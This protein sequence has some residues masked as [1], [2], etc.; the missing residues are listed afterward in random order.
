MRRA[1][2]NMLSGADDIEVQR[3]AQGGAIAL[4]RIR[5]CHPDVVVLDVEMPGM[6]GLE[7]LTEI[8]KLYPK[9]PVIMFSSLTG[10][11]TSTTVEALALGAS[12]YLS[13]PSSLSTGSVATD[14]QVELLRKIRAL[15][16]SCSAS[17]SPRLRPTPPG[18]TSRTVSQGPIKIVLIACSTGGPNALTSVIPNLPADL[19]V[20]V[21][22]VQ[23]M[24]PI[25]TGLLADRLNKGSKLTV[26]EASAGDRPTPNGCWLA[27][28]DY[29]MVLERNQTGVSLNLNQEPA[30]NSCRPAA[31]ALF[32]SAVRAYG[33][34]ILGVI[35]T[36]MGQDGLR[37]CE[38]IAEAGGQ[39]IAQDEATSVVWGMPG[40]VAVAGLADKVLPL[41][42]IAAEITNRVNASRRLQ[43]TPTELHQ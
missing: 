23:H 37:G 9:M 21:L 6:S 42:A 3:A 38:A 41:D 28:G 7:T 8:R 5:E 2:T 25:F 24:P 17:K 26:K 34:N 43:N 32:R 10:R 15:G 14:T 18:R 1:I 39:V 22:I 19:P 30:E 29:H 20:P 31:D 40:A 36:G 27:P 12:D 4:Q 11:G 33:P 35:L 13:K 16:T